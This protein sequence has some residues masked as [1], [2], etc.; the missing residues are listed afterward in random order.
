MTDPHLSL[1]S[2]QRTLSWHELAAA[3]GPSGSDADAAADAA[4]QADAGAT[5]TATPN[6]PSATANT[7]GHPQPVHVV[8]VD[9]FSGSGKTWFATRLA[10]TLG[11]PIYHVDEFVPGWDALADGIAHVED[12]LLRPWAR[13]Q[14]ALVQQYDWH[15]ARRGPWV[16][17]AAAPVV[18][19]EGSGIGTVE[20]SSI[21]ALVWVETPDAL[22]EDRLA[23]RSDRELYAPYREMWAAQE[24]ALAG[25]ARTADRA[26]V[27][28]HEAA[29]TGLRTSC[30]PYERP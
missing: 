5:A 26:D 21:S 10:R 27:V 25:R 22:R 16:Q 17:A 7:P 18:V 2:E 12:H 15:A 30:R 4:T 11:C 3:L 20:R 13:G 19:L 28:V 1:R 23:G 24:R 8:A 9:G 14:T 6:T 29:E